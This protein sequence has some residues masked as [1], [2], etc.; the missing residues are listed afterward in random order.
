MSIKRLS[1]T[2]AAGLVRKC[3]ESGRRVI[4]GGHFRDELAKEGLTLPDALHV[5]RTGRIYDEP[6]EDIKTG[7]WKYRI[8]GREVDGRVLKIVFC[9]KDFD[10]IDTA[11][12]ITVFS[13]R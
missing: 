10:E 3:L 7:E 9:F 6:E 4:P 8:E 11:Y 5:L 12:L 1:R 2:E 13:H